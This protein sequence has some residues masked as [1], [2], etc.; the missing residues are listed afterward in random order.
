MKDFLLGCLAAAGLL[1]LMIVL[2]FASGCASSGLYAM[3]DAW[4]ASHP[5]ARA[6]RC[7]SAVLAKAQSWDQENLKLHD[8]GCPTSIFIAPGGVLEQCR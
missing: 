1:S 3:S 7:P 8:H 2:A 5:G 4:C 6:S